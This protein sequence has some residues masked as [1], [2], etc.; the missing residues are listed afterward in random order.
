M[1]NATIRRGGPVVRD[2]NG[3]R[4]R[5]DGELGYH[6]G[7]VREGRGGYVVKHT[8]QRVQSP[9]VK[10]TKKLERTQTKESLRRLKQQLKR[11]A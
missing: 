7:G 10:N 6:S 2:V 8:V 1:S 4:N 11:A 9:Y 3:H 5:T